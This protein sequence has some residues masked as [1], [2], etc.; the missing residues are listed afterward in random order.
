M[1]AISGDDILVD[2]ITPASVAAHFGFKAQ[3]QKYLVD[4]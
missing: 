1:V 2:I 4:T 3:V